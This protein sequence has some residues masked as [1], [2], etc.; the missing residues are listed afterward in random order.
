RHEVV[1][2]VLGRP[3]SGFTKLRSNGPTPVTCTIV[4]PL[5]IAKCFSPL[6]IRAYVPGG[7]NRIFFVSNVSPMPSP[8]DPSI[9]VTCSSVECQC[10]G[11]LAPS[12]NFARIVNTLPSL[13]GSPESTAIFVPVGRQGGASPH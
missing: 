5:A 10:G 12:A 3:S 8:N 13:L 11:I 6:S 4:V 1:D 9:T 2:R 7:K